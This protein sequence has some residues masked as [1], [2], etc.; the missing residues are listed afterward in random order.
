[1]LT[2]KLSGVISPLVEAASMALIR[3]LPDSPDAIADAIAIEYS[4][5]GLK[6][7][8]RK[9]ESR[10]GRKVCIAMQMIMASPDLPVHNP[11]QN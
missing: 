2:A 6:R 11:T 10:V 4:A 7:S 9:V 3:V 5:K 1:M 8:M